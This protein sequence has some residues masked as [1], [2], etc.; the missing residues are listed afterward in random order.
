MVLELTCHDA[1]HHN[2]AASYTSDQGAIWY[3][4][5]DVWRER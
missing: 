5:P 1:Q 4:L 2:E 3:N